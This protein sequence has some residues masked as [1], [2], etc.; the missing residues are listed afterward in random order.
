MTVTD[1]FVHEGE[2][3]LWNFVPVADHDKPVEFRHFAVLPYPIAGDGRAANQ[4][5]VGNIVDVEVSAATGLQPGLLQR[6][7]S[8]R[9]PGSYQAVLERAFD[10]LFPELSEEPDVPPFHAL[11]T[12]W[13]GNRPSI[14]GLPGY[15]AEMADRPRTHSTGTWNLNNNEEYT[16][17]LS[18]ELLIPESGTYQFLDGIDDFAVLGIDLN[19]DG[20]VEALDDE[21]LINDNS[22]TNPTR[23]DHDGGLP[24]DVI[25][26]VNFENIPEGGE[27]FKIEAIVAEAGG[28]DSGLFY[29]DYD[30]ADLDGDGVRLGDATGFPTSARGDGRVIATN[31]L[32]N[33]LVPDTHLRSEGGQRISSGT[34]EALLSSDSAYTFELGVN[35]THDVLEVRRVSEVFTTNLDLNDATI[36]IAALG[37]LQP[38]EYDLLQADQVTGQA[39]LL[40]PEQ[41]QALLD[42][43]RFLTEGI[44]VVL[45]GNPWDCNGDGLVEVQ[46]ANCATLESLDNILTAA[47]LIKGDADGDGQVQF[48]DFVILSKAFGTAGQYTDGDFDKDGVVQFPDFAILAANFGQGTTAASV[49]EPSAVVILGLGALCLIPVNRGRH[50]T[51][52]TAAH[53]YCN[54]H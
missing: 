18:G 46:D 33:L 24:D 16:V 26:S 10:P 45:G 38:G 11:T 40:I 8:I 37:E 3:G 17:F 34:V 5:M 7:Y 36:Q 13:S 15:P 44:L 35:G 4:A 42:T 47:N 19:R 25:P 54:T 52:V 31:D 50:H 39:T 12:W 49:P 53:R 32:P 41:L 20:V 6:W 27:W 23:E 48:S 22:W 29:W 2:M 21:L 9:N 14:P 1:E 51:R 28:G 30:A 43:S